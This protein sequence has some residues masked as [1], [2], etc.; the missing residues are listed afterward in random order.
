MSTLEQ[1]ILDASTVAVLLV[2]PAEGRVVR[3]NQAAAQLLGYA[4]TD[5]LALS[6]LDIESSLQDVFYWEEVFSGT[7]SSIAWRDALYRTATDE[8]VEVSKSVSLLAHDGAT[9]LLVQAMDTRASRQVEQRLE[10]ILSRLRATLGGY[11]AKS[12]FLASSGPSQP[13]SF[14]HFPRS[15]SL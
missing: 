1:K 7:L 12:S 15:R 11:L 5:L 14:T 8:L 6:I 2:D 4:M 13:T 10:Q 9:F 3:A